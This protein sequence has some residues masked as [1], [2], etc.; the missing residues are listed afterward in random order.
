[1]ADTQQT[2]ALIILA[3]KYQDEIVKQ[4]NR[5][6]TTLS[7]LTHEPGDSSDIRWVTEADGAL[8]AA[9]AEGSAVADYGSDAQAPAVLNYG[10]YESP[11]NVSDEALS[12]AVANGNPAGNVYLWARN[13]INSSAKLASELN[14]DLFGGT[15]SN[16]LVGFDTAIGDTSNIYATINRAS[17]S[18]WRPTVSG[19]SKT[20][21][22]IQQVRGDIASIYVASGERPNLMVCHPSVF[23]RLEQVFDTSRRFTTN[24]SAPG[25][26]FLGEL[27]RPFIMIDGCMAVEDKDGYVSTDTGNIYYLNTNYVKVR[28]IPY[29]A[30]GMGFFQAP[31]DV[32]ELKFNFDYKML[33][34]AAHAQKA[35]VR[36]QA[37]LQVEKPNACGMRKF[38]SILDGDYT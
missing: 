12:R 37:Q 13:I 5:K 9:H 32:P 33:P 2:S 16:G 31:V 4:I 24:V 27:N 7:L 19:A 38:V 1:M 22:T 14:G 17:A 35:M 18:Y 23:S 25:D 34:A 28:T 3:Q 21:L 8:A 15:V 11:F 26:A 6:A 29:V 20:K 30:T 10:M 36:V